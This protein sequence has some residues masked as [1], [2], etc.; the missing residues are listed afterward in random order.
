[1]NIGT[2]PLSDSLLMMNSWL[3][4]RLSKC[5]KQ[6][7]R[8]WEHSRKFKK[9]GILSFLSKKFFKISERS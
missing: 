1:V 6:R 7:F 4:L 3:S 5:D 9:A 8:S 2:Q